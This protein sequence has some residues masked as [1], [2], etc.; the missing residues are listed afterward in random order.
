MTI[1]FS[2]RSALSLFGATIAVACTPPAESPGGGGTG[3]HDAIAAIERGLGGR[4]GVFALDTGSGRTVAF[5]EDDRF[6]MCSTFKWVLCAAV[7]LRVDKGELALTDPV[8]YGRGDL[9][10]YAPV[11]LEHVD[12]GSMTVEELA[13]AAITASDNTAANLLLGKVGGPGGLTRFVRQLGD[14]VT[15]LDRDEPQLNEN[16]DG[17]ER[18]TSS[19]KAMVGLMRAALVGDALTAASRERLL[20]WMRVSKSG[21]RRLRAGLPEGWSAGDKTGTG[22]NGATN[23]SMIATP[24][25][26]APVLVAAFMSGSR[27]PGTTL[28]AAH[29]NIARLVI[30]A[31][32]T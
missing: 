12:S 1:L 16:L 25:G 15:R 29:A 14:T 6:A 7:L 22:A 3:A 8:P 24:P 27:V 19:P 28:E 2:R 20:S 21:Q 32:S 9:L 10:E 26:G 18:D 31:L 4:V 5:R 30:S 13:R 11:T 17:D 23:D